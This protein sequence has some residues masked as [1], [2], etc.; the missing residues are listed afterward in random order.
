MSEPTYEIIMTLI[1]IYILYADD[2]RVLT[3]SK[4]EDHYIYITTLTCIFI[5][6]LEI[7]VLS[8]V[9]KG[10][11]LSFFFWMDLISTLSTFLEIPWVI[12]DL[13]G[14]SDLSTSAKVAK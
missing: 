1:T 9:R 11:I 14:L 7:I 5:F 3:V 10:Y 2:I 6:L 4:H 13:L 12:N 8:I